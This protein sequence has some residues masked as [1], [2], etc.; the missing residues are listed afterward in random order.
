MTTSASAAACAARGPDATACP[1]PCP[2]R[3]TCR[4]ATDC[5]S[6]E[7]AL[8][9]LPGGSD[10]V[11]DFA[12]AAVRRQVD[13]FARQVVLHGGAACCA[14]MDVPDMKRALSEDDL[15]A[16]LESALE[17]AQAVSACPSRCAGL[18][19]LLA[20]IATARGA[21]EMRRGARP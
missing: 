13:A 18:P 1:P 7:A 21:L 6:L 12:R 15:G 4:R 2:A 9:A 19:A 5:A 11:I 17:A 16:V 20:L 3:A 14:A 10:S 8:D